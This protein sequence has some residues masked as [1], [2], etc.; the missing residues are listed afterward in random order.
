[1]L[2]TITA[3]V[4]VLI[5]TGCAVTN[6]VKEYPLESAAVAD[7]ASTLWALNN[8]YAEA[9]P[10]G[11]PATI[12]IK[13]AVIALKDQLTACDRNSVEQWGTGLWM[14]AAVN[15]SLLALTANTLISPIMGLITAL[16]IVSQWQRT[17]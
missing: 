8:G 17:C 11:F 9:N 14:G 2:R 4:T 13:I 16:V 7:T 10:L 3:L 6:T 5:V 12:A 15:N 1:M